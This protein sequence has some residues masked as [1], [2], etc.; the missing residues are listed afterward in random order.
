MFKNEQGL[1]IPHAEKYSNLWSIKRSRLSLAQC[2][3]LFPSVEH[4]PPNFLSTFPRSASPNTYQSYHIRKS[5]FNLSV[6]K[7]LFVCWHRKFSQCLCKR[8]LAKL[9]ARES[10]TPSQTQTVAR[11]YRGPLV[12]FKFRHFTFI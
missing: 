11:P 3:L 9:G 8:I 6:F 12:L 5:H 4:P 10:R 1:V 2:L 7:S